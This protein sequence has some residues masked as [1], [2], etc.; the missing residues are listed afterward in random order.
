MGDSGNSGRPSRSRPKGNLGL[1]RIHIAPFHSFAGGAGVWTAFA[2][3]LMTSVAAVPPGINDKKKTPCRGHSPARPVT[4]L[5]DVRALLLKPK[6]RPVP[7]ITSRPSGP[8]YSKN[9]CGRRN[10][11]E[12]SN[13]YDE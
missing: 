5:A 4:D 3:V 10:F 7:P 9:S 12:D 11:Q 1:A 2:V 13:D 8:R 6:R